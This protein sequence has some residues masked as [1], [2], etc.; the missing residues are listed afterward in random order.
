MG[1]GVV[2]AA[3]LGG[4][5]H[6]YGRLDRAPGQVIGEFE[7]RDVS[8]GR[9]HR[10]SQHRGRVLVIVFVGTSC[11]VGELYIGRLAELATTYQSRNVDFLAINSNASESIAEVAQH[12]RESGVNFPVLKD[13]ENRVADELLAERT[14]ESLVIDGQGQLRYRGAIDDQ[15]GQR[16]R[17]D[18]PAHYYLTDAI[19]SVLAGR[20]VLVQET[21]V[22]GCPIERTAPARVRRPSSARILSGRADRASQGEATSHS[23]RPLPTHVTYADDV[24]PIVH[25]RCA[26]C[27]R[28]GQVAPFSL[29]TFEQARRWATSIAEVIDDGRMPPWDADPRYGQFANDRS[30][31]ARERSVLL[32]WCEQ[33]APSGDMSGSPKPPNGSQVWSIGMPDVVFEVAKPFSVPAE[34]TVPIQRVRVATHLDEDLYVHAAEA[35]PGDR[36]V[37]HHICVF[38]ED[39]NKTS[40][41]TLARD[42]LLVAYFPGE[43]PSFLPAGVAKRIPRGADLLFEV[44]YT[45]IGKPRFDRPSVGLLVW[46]EPPRHLAVTRGIPA[47]TLRIPPGDPD[48]TLRSFWT[49]KRDIH[50]LSLEPHMHL[51]GKSFVITADY[52]DGRAEILLSV[53]RYDFNWQ[54]VYRLTQPKSIPK[55]TRIHCEAHFDNSPSNPANPDPTRTV[56]WGEQSW[57]EMMIGLIDY[58]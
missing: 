51:R 10:L 49:A 39:H 52:P 5:G 2:T 56:T 34:G 14:C 15:Y 57:D 16:T 20:R 4:L 11:P 54:T 7:L 37:V 42:N 48:Y 32:S 3:L 44:H 45:P 26:P 31:S 17:Q 50:L 46:H 29:L 9:L 21:H 19:E 33:G 53:P 55:G 22:V 43:T 30:L 40:A 47:H 23:S 41:S 36:A 8:T 27:H 28:P 1:L 18:R 12:A 6:R 58:Y 35:R 38:V 25:A 24:A 13:P